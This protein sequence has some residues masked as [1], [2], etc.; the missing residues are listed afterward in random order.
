MAD[1]HHS[2]LISRIISVHPR[3]QEFLPTLRKDTL[4][5]TE[6]IYA[7]KLEACP[8]PPAH[9]GPTPPIQA[10]HFSPYSGTL[11][12]MSNANDNDDASGIDLG[13]DFAYCLGFKETEKGIETPY[14][15]L[16]RRNSDYSSSQSTNEGFPMDIIWG[17]SLTAN[18]SNSEDDS[19]SSSKS[20]NK[21]KKRR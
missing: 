3:Y 20:K 7:W 13:S 8:R 18:D 2:D 19:D 6:P 1:A 12:L 9:L 15:Y 16:S 21:K 5:Q 10:V 11:P 14:E 17:E 4:A